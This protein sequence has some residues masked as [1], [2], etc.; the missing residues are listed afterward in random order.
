MRRFAWGFL[1]SLLGLPLV[2][3]LALALG[4]SLTYQDALLDFE[5]AVEAISTNT[6]LLDTEGK[7][8]HTLHSGERRQVVE[9]RETGR[10]MQLSVLAAEDT[11][12][13][14]HRGVDPIRILSALW[15]NLR[16]GEVKQGASTITQQL[17]KVLLLSP[18]RTWTRKVREAL[19]SI[20]LEWKYDKTDILEAY[21]NTIFLGHGNYGVEQAAQSYFRKHAAEL[22]IGEASLLGGIIRRPEFYLK[23]PNNLPEK[24]EFYPQS[25]LLEALNRRELVLREMARQRWITAEQWREVR[26]EKLQVHLPKRFSG[27]GAYFIQEVVKRLKNNHNLAQVYGGGYRVYTTYNPELQELAEAATHSIYEGDTPHSAQ[28]ALV[29]MEPKTGFVRALVG[30]RDFGESEFNRAVQA[31]RQPGSSFKPTLYATA[32]EKSFAPNNVFKD[33]PLVYEWVDDLGL[34]SFYSPGN[35]DGKFGKERTWLG[36]NGVEYTT[37]HMTLAKA[38]ERSVNTVAVQVLDQLGIGPLTQQAKKVGLEVDGKMG[39]CIALGCS[40]TTLLD[41]TTSYTPFANGGIARRPVFITRIEDFTGNI[42]Y[43]YEAD[44]GI[45]AYSPWTAHLMNEMLRRVVLKG[46][47]RNAQWGN[48][49]VPIAGKTGTNTDGR[50]AWFIGY[51]PELVTGVWIGKDDNTA[52]P[53]E[54][55]GRTPARIWRRY[56]KPALQLVPPQEFPE[57]PEHALMPTCSVSGKLATQNCPD[58]EYYSYQLDALPTEY[59]TE[60]PG[61]PLKHLVSMDDTPVAELPDALVPEDA[62]VAQPEVLQDAGRF[63]APETLARPLPAVPE[64]AL[65]PS[66]PASEWRPDSAP[67]EARVLPEPTPRFRD[68]PVTEPEFSAQP[69]SQERTSRFRDVPTPEPEAS[70]LSDAAADPDWRVPQDPDVPIFELEP[71]SGS[72]RNSSEGGRFL[73]LP[74]VFNTPYSSNRGALPSR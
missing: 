2:G 74:E 35:A 69:T 43:K 8:F 32:L 9:R 22:T 40:G 58:V 33:E 68:V 31:L 38:L 59:C 44:P 15:V 65:E 24:S 39:L 5:Q 34:T 66:P 45:Q 17:V 49:D 18:E 54:Q 48:R 71:A 16:H 25:A 27:S 52:M 63:P 41:L 30:G 23:V 67:R 20:S 12:F 10:W 13:F 46:T 26:E 55:G 42:V 53:W 7:P 50:D 73:D 1:F 70:T 19:I 29:S 4:L 72:R 56:S 61:F 36:R 11:R 60:H 28:V 3:V 14:H 64:V 57:P 37:D 21:L 47:G 51:T 62:T 6:I